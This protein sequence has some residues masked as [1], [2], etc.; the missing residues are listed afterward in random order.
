MDF[1]L[2]DI[3]NISANKIGKI[4]LKVDFKSIIMAE[5]DMNLKDIGL[6]FFGS[7]EKEEV[8]AI[9]ARVEDLL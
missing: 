9:T 7:T 8:D 5:K 1:I 2:V 6:F 4:Y 3:I